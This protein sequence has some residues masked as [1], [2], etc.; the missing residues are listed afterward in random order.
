MGAVFHLLL[1]KLPSAPGAGAV[2]P[3]GLCSPAL[4][5]PGAAPLPRFLL[6]IVGDR[7]RGAAGGD[8]ANV[9]SG[10]VLLPTRPPSLHPGPAHLVFLSPSCW[11]RVNIPGWVSETCAPPHYPAPWGDGPAPRTAQITNFQQHP[12]A[13]KNPTRKSPL[14][15]AHTSLGISRS[16]YPAPLRGAGESAGFA[17]GKWTLSPYP[18]RVSPRPRQPCRPS[19]RLPGSRHSCRPPP[20]C[21]LQTEQR[22]LALL[23]DTPLPAPLWPSRGGRMCDGAERGDGFFLGGRNRLIVWGGRAVCGL[24]R[25]RC[26]TFRGGKGIG[27]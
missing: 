21:V 25:A 20:C 7:E 18:A 9:A 6:R 19:R 11:H 5:S 13:P 16:P 24:G 8:I 10:M 1:W 14:Q 27:K 15:T 4:L 2:T 23:P 22:A 26:C 3:S 12:P 17:T